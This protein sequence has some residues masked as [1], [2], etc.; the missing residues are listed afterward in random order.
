MGRGSDSGQGF[1]CFHVKFSWIGLS[2]YSKDLVKSQ[3]FGNQPVKFSH[4]GM[5]SVKK[6]KK[7]GLGADRTLGS[8]GLNLTLQVF[9]IGKVHQQILDI[10]G[11]A[12]SDRGRLGRL[13]MGEAQGGHILISIAECMQVGYHVDKRLFNQGKRLFLD[14][15]IRITDHE[16]GG[17]AKMDNCL[18]LWT[19]KA[20]GVDMGHHIMAY[21]FFLCSRNFKIN[22]VYV[23]FKFINHLLGD[24][25]KAKFMLGLGQGNPA[26]PPGGEFET[27]GKQ[28]LHFR[29]GISTDQGLLVNISIHG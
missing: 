17:G 9:N 24:Q 13:V 18:G 1:S 26:A 23:F 20:I 5:I 7:G 4:L 11:I 10:Q 2:G 3:F 16:L 14:N 22:V 28:F 19:L 6:L 21:F 27:L 8:P 25:F 15:K 12:L 29:A